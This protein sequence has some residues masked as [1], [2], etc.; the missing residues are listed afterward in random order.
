MKLTVAE[1]LG[2]LALVVAAYI[3]WSIRLRVFMLFVVAI[4]VIGLIALHLLCF[5]LVSKGKAKEVYL[6]RSLKFLS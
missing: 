2:A 1:I 5:F 6:V 4:A 3:L